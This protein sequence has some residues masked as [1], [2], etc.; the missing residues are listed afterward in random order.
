VADERQD[1]LEVSVLVEGVEAARL[2]EKATENA[3]SNYSLNVSLSEKDRGTDTLVLTFALELTSQPQAAK[4]KIS[5]SATLKGSREDIKEGITAPDE[6]KP[7]PILIIIYERIYG[8]VYLL[9]GALK[10]PHPMPNLL[11]KGP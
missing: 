2:S 9:S 11:K 4:F 7:P 3:N 6:N 8:T 10:V 1:V 5:G